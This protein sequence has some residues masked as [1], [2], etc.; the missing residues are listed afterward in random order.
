[1]E[2]LVSAVLGVERMTS[3]EREQ[4]ADEIHARQPNLLYSVIV[5]H[6]FGATF[7]Q[8]DVVLDLLFVF[9][10]AMKI[11]GRTWPVITE[12]V[13]DRCLKRIEGRSRFDE[14]LTPLQQTQVT[15]DFITDHP[16]Q[17]LLAYLMGK[18]REHGLHGIESETEKMLMLVALNLVEC[19][20]HTAPRTT[21]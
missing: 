2:H 3:K 10:E 20:A 4:L 15:S 8:M 5:L 14:G 12:D 1:M 17:Q 19:I 9:Y 7:A 13:Q 18:F 21:G 11:S 16:Q 6:R